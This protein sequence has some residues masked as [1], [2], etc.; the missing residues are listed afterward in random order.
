MVIAIKHL[1][2]VCFFNVY[3]RLI[4][5]LVTMQICSCHYIVET[6]VNWKIP[7]HTSFPYTIFIVEYSY[8]DCNQCQQ[9][10][11]NFISHLMTP[12]N[13][14]LLKTT[15]RW[16]QL[17]IFVNESFFQLISYKQDSIWFH[18]KHSCISCLNVK[19]LI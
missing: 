6:L 18:S 12:L 13:M 15:N 14:K 8:N 10:K 17:T 4:I 9:I 11:E 16:Q 2:H 5:T 1:S 19:V 3:L 7:L